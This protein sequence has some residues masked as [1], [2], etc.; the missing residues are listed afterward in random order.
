MIVTL[1]F[2]LL[3]PLLRES[4]QSLGDAGQLLVLLISV[5]ILSATIIAVRALTHVKNDARSRQRLELALQASEGAIDLGQIA[6]ELPRGPA[7]TLLTALK[8]TMAR[9]H[10]IG[11][12]AAAQLFDASLRQSPQSLRYLAATSVLMGLLGTFLGILTSVEAYS[13]IQADADQLL[14]FL[15]ELLSGFEQAFSTTIL[16]LSASAIIG[17]HVLLLNSALEPETSALSLTLFGRLVPLLQE[18]ETDFVSRVIEASMNRMLPSLIRETSEHLHAAATQ[19]S[20]S[21]VSFH[22]S[23]Q[24]FQFAT[25]PVADGIQT[26]GS[27]TGSL[28]EVLATATHHLDRIAASNQEVAS[29]VTRLSVSHSDIIKGNSAIVKRLEVL[30]ARSESTAGVAR[31]SA[32]ALTEV[33][34]RQTTIAEDATSLLSLLDGRVREIMSWL[35]TRDEDHAGKFSASIDRLLSS[36]NTMVST[37]EK[38]RHHLQ[39]ISAASETAAAILARDAT[40]SGHSPESVAKAPGTPMRDQ[41]RVSPNDWPRLLARVDDVAAV[42]ARIEQQL[43]TRPSVASSERAMR[44][45]SSASSLA[46]VRLP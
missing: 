4:W 11:L 10:R 5:F 28:R 40:T 38:H 35:S 46:W 39:A 36:Q 2:F 41:T 6:D 44:A 17:A 1:P 37:L 34:N 12:D 21:A 9:G 15:A 26:L 14:T 27:V 16:G 43:Q 3:L 23:A 25:L 32:E 29:D 7:K 18:P 24:A 19:I 33:A 42:L 20:D 45:D 8:A 22:D 13:I 31:R 30:I